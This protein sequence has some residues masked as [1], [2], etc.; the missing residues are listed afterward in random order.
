M[1]YDKPSDVAFGT[2]RQMAADLAE[3]TDTLE[4][5]LRDYAQAFGE[6]STAL[7]RTRGNIVRHLGPLELE[8][9]Y[10][11]QLMLARDS[12]KAARKIRADLAMVL[13]GLPGR[14]RRRRRGGRSG[15]DS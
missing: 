13:A 4:G 14:S 10:R 3:L 1:E 7:R 2:I 5:D 8:G 11:I 12:G 6:L 9:V 15:L